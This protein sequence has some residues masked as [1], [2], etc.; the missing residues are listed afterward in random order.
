[1]HSSTIDRSSETVAGG[2]FASGL[3]ATD[4][5]CDTLEK[6][7]LQQ[8]SE[9][10]VAHELGFGSLAQQHVFCTTRPDIAHTVTV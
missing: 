2:M 3:D 10:I 7:D 8:L 5:A 6:R 9:S 4:V 1:M